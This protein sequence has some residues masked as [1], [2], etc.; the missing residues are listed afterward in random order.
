MHQA[1]VYISYAWGD[2]TIAGKRRQKV[3]DE[4]HA[5]LKKKGFNTVVD[6]EG[7]RYKESIKNFMESL[8]KARY[9]VMIVSDRYLKSKSCMFEVTQMLAHGEFKKR[10]FPLV[11]PDAKIY[12]PKGRS[13]YLEYWDK[14]IADQEKLINELSNKAYAQ[15]EF[16]ELN[17]YND[18]RRIVNSFNSVIGDMNTMNLEHHKAHDYKDIVADLEKRILQDSGVGSLEKAYGI[19]QLAPSALPNQITQQYQKLV[20]DNED[21]IAKAIMPEIKQ[22]H[23]EAA[24]KLKTAY[25]MLLPVARKKVVQEK[26]EIK[27][28]IRSKKHAEAK[29]LLGKLIGLEPQDTELKELLTKCENA[30]T[31]STDGEDIKV[32]KKASEA[33]KEAAKA[34]K[35]VKEA[36]GRRNKV[37]SNIETSDTEGKVV[38]SKKMRKKMQMQVK[39]REEVKRKALR[40]IIIPSAFAVLAIIAGFTVKEQILRV[41]VSNVIGKARQH[42]LTGELST[43]VRLLEDSSR[44][45]VYEERLAEE[46]KR[47]QVLKKQYDELLLKIRSYKK[48]KKWRLAERAMLRILEYTPKDSFMIYQLND[49]QKELRVNDFNFWLLTAEEAMKQ[50]EPGLIKAKSAMINAKE[51]KVGEKIIEAN[52]KKIDSLIEIAFDRHLVKLKILAREPSS[53]SDAIN[54]GEQALL[55]KP[56]HPEV[57]TI[58][59]GLK[60][61]L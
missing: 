55:L 26:S 1:E 24:H 4:L 6:F 28:L 27:R 37:G 42:V 44:D 9:I 14:V 18:I 49:V 20:K 21:G 23:I 5:L 33:K 47:F 25:D 58:M 51:T 2:G 45:L 29:N 59:K 61:Q 46:L 60:K 3:F 13:T 36:T 32:G 11:L 35:K 41:H 52:L 7:I 38:Q 48:Q 34:E 8:G 16:D 19:L 43:A 17:L 12:T 31:L 39:D 50:G 10:I 30:L 57:S 53:I 40:R 15:S 22:A 56:G 54:E